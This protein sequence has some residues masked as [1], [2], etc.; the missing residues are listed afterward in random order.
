LTTPESQEKRKNDR[1]QQF[2][3]GEGEQGGVDLSSIPWTKK[4]ETERKT[5][6]GMKPQKES[7]G[8]HAEGRWKHEGVFRPR[9]AT[10][11]LN[12]ARHRKSWDMKGRVKHETIQTNQRKK[13]RR[14]SRGKGKKGDVKKAQI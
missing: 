8:T 4:Q 3:W 12:V 11:R 7:S 9:R 6:P 14:K 13:R 5:P 2:G 1:Y 10:V